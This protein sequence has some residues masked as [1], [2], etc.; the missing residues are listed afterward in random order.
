MV[1]VTIVKKKKRFFE[2]EI[3]SYEKNPLPREKSLSLHELQRLRLF[4][5]GPKEELAWKRRRVADVLARI[6]DVDVTVDPVNLRGESTG[7]RN[8]MQ[9]RVKDRKLTLYGKGGEAIS[10]KRCL[11]Q[12][13]RANEILAAMQGKSGW[14]RWPSWA[15]APPAA[16]RA[17]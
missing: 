5:F 4:V 7:Y 2:G 9:F 16:A 13:E 12:T 10:I 17:W 1:D 14:M 11:M 3:L 6:G 15:F 8:H